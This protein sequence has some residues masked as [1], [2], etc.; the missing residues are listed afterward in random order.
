[1]F[2]FQISITNKDHKLVLQTP[3]QFLFQAI[4]ESEV[5]VTGLILLTDQ[6]IKSRRRNREI[7]K[8]ERRKVKNNNN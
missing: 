7:K 1:M 8:S 3:T 2:G 5:L 6:K 4:K